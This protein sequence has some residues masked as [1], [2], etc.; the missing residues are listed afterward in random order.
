MN[1]GRRCTL[2]RGIP[3]FFS[4]VIVHAC[5]CH[6]RG[7]RHTLSPRGRIGDQ[8]MGA[9]RSKRSEMGKWALWKFFASVSSI[10]PHLPPT[11]ILTRSSLRTFLSNYPAVYV[12]PN[13]GQQGRSVI[14]VWKTGRGSYAFI[15]ERGK[16]VHCGTTDEVYQKIK[17]KRTQIVQA[18]I[19]L[20]RIRG[21]PFDV[22]VLMMRDGN[23]RWQYAGM[24]AKVAGPGWI[25]TNK[26]SHG[27]VLTVDEALQKSLQWDSLQIGKIKE[28]MIQLGHDICKR[29][30][31]YKRYR[32]IGIDMGVD[33]NGKIWIIEENTG[34]GWTLFAKLKDRSMYHK[35]RSILRERRQ[36]VHL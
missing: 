11:K 28:Q 4:G 27:S 32:Q 36:Q 1:V 16:A 14:K 24:L 23:G 6:S 17:S 8:G 7:S 21:R 29:F 22:R 35:I 33:T 20:A 5:H 25:I 18:S 2:D 34:P 31:E 3:R 15:R 13:Y 10:R 9:T 12:K 30:D 26:R 19:D